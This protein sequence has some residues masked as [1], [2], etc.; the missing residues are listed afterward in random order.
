VM[1]LIEHRVP[2]GKRSIVVELDLRSLRPLREE[3]LRE[4]RKT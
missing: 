2:K 1:E 4:L 3:R